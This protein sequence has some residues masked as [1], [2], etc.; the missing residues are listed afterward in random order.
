MPEASVNGFQ[1]HYA[2]DDFTDPWVPH[3]VVIMQHGFMRSRKFFY[4][5][6][7]VF[8]RHYAVVRPDLLG[9]GQSEA[10][11]SG[12]QWSLEGL[13][14]NVLALLDHLGVDKVHYVG[15]SLGGLT[16]AT[17]AAMHPERLRSLV[18]CS[19]PLSLRHQ[20]GGTMPPGYK[21]RDKAVRKLGHWGVFLANNQ[22]RVQ[23]ASIIEQLKFGWMWT[24]YRKTPEHV[25]EGIE[26]MVHQPSVD[27][28]AVLPKIKTPTLL[29]SPGKSPAARLEDQKRM[30]TL[31]PNCRQVVFPEGGHHF[32]MDYAERASA[33]ALEFVREHSEMAHAGSAG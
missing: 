33:L 8:A 22:G 6:A 26:A 17:F 24:E 29:L 9:H 28:T 20:A 32:Y 19:T 18:L 12:F 5:W 7:P 21:N 14:N 27:L 2:L 30:A 16:G 23:G 3:E 13:A 15:E 11:P 31:I 1:M 4:A 25:V 10:P